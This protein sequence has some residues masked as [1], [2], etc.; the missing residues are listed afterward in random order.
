MTNEQRAELR[1]MYLDRRNL[2]PCKVNGNLTRVGEERALDYLVGI[3]YGMKIAG[4]ADSELPTGLVFLASV[5]GCDSVLLQD[6]NE[7]G[8]FKTGAQL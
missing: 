1:K 7:D 8:T 6:M 5:R 3:A 4:T 2:W